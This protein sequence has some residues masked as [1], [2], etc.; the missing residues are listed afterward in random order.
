MQKNEVQTCCSIENASE[1]AVYASPSIPCRKWWKALNKLLQ[2]FTKDT[3]YPQE[4]EKTGI[5]IPENG[6][7]N[8]VACW[9]SHI[10]IKPIIAFDNMMRKGLHLEREPTL[11]LIAATFL[12]K[13]FPRPQPPSFSVNTLYPQH[14]ASFTSLAFGWKTYGVYSQLFTLTQIPPACRLS[15]LIPPSDIC[16]NSKIPHYFLASFKHRAYAVAPL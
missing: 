11:L 8:L 2:L 14:Y 1:N 12:G 7:A 5:N 13:D 4:V 9:P 16:P 6:Q 3:H 15:L 10:Q